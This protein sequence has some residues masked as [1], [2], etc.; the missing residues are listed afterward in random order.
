MKKQNNNDDKDYKND[1]NNI[2]NTDD[3]AS[4]LFEAIKKEDVDAINR[5][6]HDF[7]SVGWKMAVIYRF[8]TKK[9][10]RISC[11]YTKSGDII[12]L[13]NGKFDIR[14]HKNYLEMFAESSRTKNRTILNEHFKSREKMNADELSWIKSLNPNDILELNLLHDIIRKNG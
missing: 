12:F 7:A 4:R 10:D 13:V 5:G 8:I 9:G 14:A 1:V 3:I 6:L 11:I 2:N